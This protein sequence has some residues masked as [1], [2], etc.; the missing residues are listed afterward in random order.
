MD[1]ESYI[2]SYG[3][4]SHGLFALLFSRYVTKINTKK[5]ILLVGHFLITATMVNR[6]SPQSR[7][8]NM[9]SLLGSLAHGFVAVFFILTT[10]IFNNK[11]YRL[12][13]DKGSD[14]WLNIV[15]IVGQ[16]GMIIMYGSIYF[17]HTYKETYE[18]YENELNYGLIITFMCLTYFYYRVY[19]KQK[20]GE[21]LVYPLG[22]ICI[23]YL[24][25]F[26]HKVYSL[27]N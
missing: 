7:E 16:L 19:I 24:S 4:L 22:M 17:K 21:V 27:K 6:I 11:K 2:V 23:L 3:A 1:I 10:F 9:T 8:S 5:M 15:C 20:K 12:T 14:N 13:F 26:A 18:K 25:F